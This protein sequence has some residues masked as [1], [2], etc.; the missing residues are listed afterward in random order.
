LATQR[1]RAELPG[2]A[3]VWVEATHVSDDPEAEV[4]AVDVSEVLKLDQVSKVIAGLAELV[5]TGIAEAKPTKA[6]AEF[7]LDVSL[8]SG[9]LTALWVKGTGKASI[10][11]TLEW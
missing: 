2:G 8:E 7:A 4:A 5:R 1:V 9:Q 3:V 10:K 6:T 11:V